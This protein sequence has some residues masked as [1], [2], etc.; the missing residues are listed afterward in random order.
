MAGL[1]TI[2]VSEKAQE[3]C[4]FE[5]NSVALFEYLLLCMILSN[6]SELILRMWELEP[7]LGVS[8][9]EDAKQSEH[10]VIDN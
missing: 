3:S 4:D 1:T 9:G 10:A 2:S 5:P 7:G 6:G 8:R